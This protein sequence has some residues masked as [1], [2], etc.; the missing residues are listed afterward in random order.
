MYHQKAVVT[1]LTRKFMN[2]KKIK[3]S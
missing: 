1:K 2:I 3:I